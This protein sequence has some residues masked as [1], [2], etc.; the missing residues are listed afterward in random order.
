M[1]VTA[2]VIA[3]L[4]VSLTLSCPDEKNCLGCKPEKTNQCAYCEYGFLN[5]DNKKCDFGLS[6]KIDFCREYLKGSPAVCIACEWGFDVG[7]NEKGE[8][9]CIPCNQENCAQCVSKSQKCT[10][11]FAPS[12]LAA[13]D[14]KQV[15]ELKK[16]EKFPNCKVSQNKEGD[17]IEKCL[18]CISGYMLTS[19][20]L[21][22]KD[23][24]GKCWWGEEGEAA[25]RTCHW[26]TY[27]AKDGSCVLN[28]LHPGEK[29]I[30][31]E[32]V[33]LGVFLLLVALAGFTYFFLKSR[34][35]SRH[36]Y[37]TP[38]LQN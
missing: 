19:K 24:F 1:K 14:D 27:L 8:S 7:T 29:T 31:K 15:C 34:K 13:K 37:E 21:C 11:C 26:G 4:L 6:R 32:L 38:I 35:S 20:Q 23:K 22:V 18:Q 12:L 17:E 9:V 5:N 30:R 10:A 33:M 3:T 16:E 25:C 36:A 28:E 2:L